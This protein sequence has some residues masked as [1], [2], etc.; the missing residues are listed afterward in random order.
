LP[1]L[2]TR[3]YENVRQEIS[4]DPRLANA[5]NYETHLTTNIQFSPYALS[6]GIYTEGARN[7]IL[8]GN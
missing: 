7:G 5:T 2:E 8:I 6:I 4:S 1:S 3:V